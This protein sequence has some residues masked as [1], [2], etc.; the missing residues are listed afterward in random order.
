[1]ASAAIVRSLLVPRYL[2]AAAPVGRSWRSSE[3]AR[4]KRRSPPARRPQSQLC[5]AAADPSCIVALQL[6][7]RYTSHILGQCCPGDCHRPSTYSSMWRLILEHVRV[8][9][10]CTSPMHPHAQPDMGATASLHQG[11]LFLA[12]HTWLGHGWHAVAF[13][14]SAA[15]AILIGLPI[16]L[17]RY[18]CQVLRRHAVLG[19]Q[20]SRSVPAPDSTFS[21][22]TT[23]VISHKV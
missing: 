16:S 6:V 13:L 3:W 18:Q 4:A 19:L 1:M 5:A 12:S 11:H 22:Y 10:A 2:A 17:P 14:F 15:C 23:W 9:A 8:L 7:F 20:R 21:L